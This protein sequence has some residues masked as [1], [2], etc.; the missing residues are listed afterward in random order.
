MIM[1][2]PECAGYPA[3]WTPPGNIHLLLRMDLSFPS[4]PRPKLFPFDSM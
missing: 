3:C 4:P 2:L 1:V